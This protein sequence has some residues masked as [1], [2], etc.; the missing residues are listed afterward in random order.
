V[1]AITSSNGYLANPPGIGRNVFRGPRYFNVD[2]SL[3]KRFGLPDFGVLGERPN[4][5]LRFNFFNI[6]NITN[7]APFQ[8]FSNST[9]TDRI[10]FGEATALLAGRVI[11][12]QA[13][14][15]F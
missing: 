9:R 13:R 8:S 5:D 2:M 15:S 14:F 1:D 4:L 6:F 7:I 3:S 11:E 12:F 10:N